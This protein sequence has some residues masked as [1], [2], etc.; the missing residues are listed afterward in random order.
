LF[1]LNIY[2][3]Y[4]NGLPDYNTVREAYGL[5]DK[6]LLPTFTSD[7]LVQAALDYLYAGD[8][9]AIDVYVGMLAEDQYVSPSLPLPRMLNMPSLAFLEELLVHCCVKLLWSK[10]SE[11]EM[12]I[13]S[14]SKILITLLKMK[15]LL[16]TE[17]NSR[18]VYFPFPSL[19]HRCL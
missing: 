4:D 16:F 3:G 14:G 6:P 8:L 7:L 17:P 9:N 12:E 2:R 15:L 13:D 18:F 19:S 11:P 5:P 10:W 1:A